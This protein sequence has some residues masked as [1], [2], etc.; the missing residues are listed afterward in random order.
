M[1]DRTYTATFQ[2]PDRNTATR[3]ETALAELTTPAEAITTRILAGDQWE[4]VAYFS[5]PPDPHALQPIAA[6]SST[7]AV[8]IAELPDVD[9]VT[10]SHRMLPPVTIGRFWIHRSDTS[11]A[12]PDGLHPL[13]VEASEAFGT[14]HHA[15]TQGCLL[16]IDHLA[17]AGIMPTTICDL[18]CGTAI[19]AMAAA[20]C[21]PA[22]I[23]ATD[24]DERAIAIAATTLA[25]NG[26]TDPI[27]LA[28]ASGFNHPMHSRTQPYDLI[29]ANLLLSEI[30]ALAGDASEHCR[31]GGRIVLAG[32]LV[33]QAERVRT[34]CQ[35]F[36]LVEERALVLDDW[37]TL[38]MRR[39]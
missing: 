28:V 18:G 29:L 39:F 30:L 27:A 36:G 38:M 34:A 24:H 22:T 21:W 5:A 16:A 33:S 9:W 1:D 13:C 32:L 4:V 2:T 20:R 25:A 11:H 3:I 31:R 35:R 23:I 8:T 37:I 6:T 10:E 26:L 14:G 17:Q 15:S 7:T 12:R 19:L